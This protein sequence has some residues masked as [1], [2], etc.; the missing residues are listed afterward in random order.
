MNNQNKIQSNT[1]KKCQYC[2]TD[3]SAGA[4][5]CPNCQSDLRSWSN[6]HQILSVLILIAVIIVTPSVVSEI[7]NFSD[8]SIKTNS[9][10]QSGKQSALSLEEVKNKAIDNVGYDE[11]LRNNE[12][13]VG[14]V[15][16]YKGE[17]NQ[18]SE[19]WGDNY[20]LRIFVTKNDYFW[21]DDIY[22]NYA[23]ER[24]LED[25]IVEI[26]GEVKG[27][28]KYTTVLG[29]VRSIPEIDALYIKVVEEQEVGKVLDSNQTSKLKSV[30]LGYSRQKPVSAG[31]SLSIEHE[32]LGEG[33]NIKITLLEIIRGAEAWKRIE[34]ENMFN[35]PS[36]SGFEYL[37]AKVKFEYIEGSAKDTT[38]RLSGWSFTAVSSEGKDYDD[39][40][41]V[42]PEP[43]L[44]STL[45]EGASHTGWVSFCVEK[46][47][48]K[49][50]MTF[51][52][53]YDG[54][55]GV[56]FKLY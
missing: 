25:D 3:I 12:K 55:G 53:E 40:S 29:A 48:S 54:T 2:Q 45:Y 56:W 39:A 46:K 17:V 35:D 10:G 22:V 33:Y 19:S 8:T 7:I 6:R 41:V 32:F 50:L 20:V 47:D 34:E 37:L 26:W 49:P 43:R 28:K 4:K 18:V 9:I 5:K 21:D 14:K 11:L 16:Y 36:D 52:R 13:Y 15:V 42:D 23:G 27:I 44:E 30:P 24:I 1:T 38:Y 51:G 31:T